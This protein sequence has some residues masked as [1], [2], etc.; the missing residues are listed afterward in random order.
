[1]I[2][3]TDQVCGVLISTPLGDM[4]LRIETVRAPATARYF[5][6]DVDAG[7]FDG[8]SFYRIATDANQDDDQPV[9]IEVIQGGLPQP[10]QA[11]PP[12][13]R[14]ESTA[15]TGLRHE[16]GTISLA[17]FAPGAVYHSFFLCRREEPSLDHGGSRNPDGQGFPA[18][19]RLVDG[20]DVLDRLFAAAEPREALRRGIPIWRIHRL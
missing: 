4:R 7:R 14:H 5:L 13:L 9:P 20:F 11:P 12:S 1:M 2:A 10:H 19:G 16:R 8:T 18:F 6:E 17:R 3:A 15:E